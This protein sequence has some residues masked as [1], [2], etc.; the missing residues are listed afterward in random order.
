MP[1]LASYGTRTLRIYHRLTFTSY[2]SS[3]IF[4]LL[5]LLHTE[6]IRGDRHQ[7]VLGQPPTGVAWTYLSQRASGYIAYGAEGDSRNPT[8]WL[9][10]VAEAERLCRAD[11]PFGGDE[12]NMPA[13]L[14]SVGCGR[15]RPSIVGPA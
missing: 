1:H 9:E 3:C 11:V 2:F 6:F 10:R 5:P 14:I 13:R 12:T 8:V 7:V 4:V 15:R